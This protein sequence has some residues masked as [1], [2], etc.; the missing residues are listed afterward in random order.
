MQAIDYK[1][2]VL[3]QNKK[4]QEVIDLIT[5]IDKNT[6]TY[7]LKIRLAY[8][9]NQMSEPCLALDVLKYD[10]ED[11]QLSAKWNYAMA[12]AYQLLAYENWNIDAQRYD[13]HFNPFFY[14]YIENARHY[15]EMACILQPF[16]TTF[17]CLKRVLDEDFKT[18]KI[19]WN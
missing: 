15:V 12:Q 18:L 13:L 16:N 4:Y 9:F 8:A 5:S 10:M 6:W 2:A 17:L 11:G 7:A 19:Q 14:H 3:Y 1:S